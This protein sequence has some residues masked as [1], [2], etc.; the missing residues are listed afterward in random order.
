MNVSRNPRCATGSTRSV[1]RGLMRAR[2]LASWV[3]TLVIEFNA[4]E[5]RFEFCSLMTMEKENRISVRA[6]KN[7]S[8]GN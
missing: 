8:I 1:R 2:Q 5:V 3:R 6:A 7:M 4:L